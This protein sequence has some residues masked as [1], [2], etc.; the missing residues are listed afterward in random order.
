MDGL[1]LL[2]D[3]QRL[4]A[5]LPAHIVNTTLES[6]FLDAQSTKIEYRTSHNVSVN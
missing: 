2:G 5:R 3:M 1:G 6:T 4:K